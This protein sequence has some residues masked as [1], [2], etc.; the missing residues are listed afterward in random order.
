MIK[1]YGMLPKHERGRW[2][3]PRWD[4]ETFR[5]MQIGIPPFREKGTLPVDLEVVVAYS[6]YLCKYILMLGKV[7]HDKP[8]I[9]M[10][11]FVEAKHCQVCEAGNI[12]LVDTAWTE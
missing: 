7:G 2:I 12:L 9:T 6:E 10:H 4:W 11:S 3:K 1:A 8:Q 5:N